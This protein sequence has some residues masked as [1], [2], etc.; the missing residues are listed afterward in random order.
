MKRPTVEASN[1]GLGMDVRFD[2]N[3]HRVRARSAPRTL[4]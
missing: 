2:N 4:I 1:A 3:V